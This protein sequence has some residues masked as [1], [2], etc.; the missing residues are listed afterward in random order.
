MVNIPDDDLIY[1]INIDPSKINDKNILITGGTGSF[2]K[3][4]I[5]T[6]LR[7]FTPKKVIIY[8]R[9]E[10]KQSLLKTM[11]NPVKHPC[12]RFFIGDVRDLQR[13]TMA[14]KGVD[15]VFHTA[16]LKRIQ[17]CEYNPQETIKTNIIGTENV[18]K[19]AI[20]NNVKY[21]IGLSTDKA[22]AP[23]N[24]YGATK[25]VGEKVMINGNILSGNSSED[26]NATKF[27]V[28]RYGNQLNSRGSLVEIFKRL[29]DTNQPLTVT[30]AS[31]TR[32]TIL[33]QEAVNFVLMC[34]DRMVGGEIFIP[35]LPSY[36]VEQM[37]RAFD[38]LEDYQIIGTRAGE[39]YHEL[40]ISSD[41]S[42][43]AWEFDN[44]FIIIPSDELMVFNMNSY[45]L[46][47]LSG[48]RRA[49]NLPY[50]SGN[51]TIICDHRLKRLI[52]AEI[53]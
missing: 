39:K 6:L 51:T 37:V 49:Q 13:M 11:F 34:L 28:V 16:A 45:N 8:S 23:V 41:E 38:G 18:V 47:G 33:L 17:E 7:C 48:T 4:M 50:S 21:V 1:K 15:I 29:K 2:G 30:D 14:F 40:M 27:A 43:M 22:C 31:M 12:L 5:S 36:S 19:A 42:H 32:F 35:K 46:A 53:Q 52:Q 3:K 20:A 44:F 9:D 10:Y 25:L 24:L 26:S